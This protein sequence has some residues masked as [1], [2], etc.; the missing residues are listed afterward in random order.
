MLGHAILLS[1]ACIEDIVKIFR[2]LSLI[3][4]VCNSSSVGVSDTQGPNRLQI[5]V[6]QVFHFIPF[7]IK[8]FAN[9]FISGHNLKAFI[10]SL[11][12]RWLR[13]NIHNR[14]LSDKEHVIV[15]L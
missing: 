2:K 12:Q 8:M 14:V 4:N 13:N 11:M 5:P 1:A 7:A 15:K 10:R 3:I 9:M 6:F